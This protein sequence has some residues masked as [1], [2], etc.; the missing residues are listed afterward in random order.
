MTVSNKSAKYI[1]S[2]TVLYVIVIT[3]YLC[4][5]IQS[6]CIMIIQLEIYVF[7]C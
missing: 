7:N 1:M 4:Y 6:V 3:S 5:C 2:H